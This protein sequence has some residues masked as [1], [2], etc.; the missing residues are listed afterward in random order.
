MSSHAARAQSQPEPTAPQPGRFRWRVVDIVVASVVA[1]ATG[2]LFWIW[3]SSWSAMS[4]PFAAFPPAAGLL[5][6]VWC[7]AGPLGALIIRKPGA[8]LYCEL[9]AATVS[10]L[11]GTQWGPQVLISGFIQGLGAELVFLLFFYRRFGIGVAILAGLGAGLFLG[12]SE[13]IMYNVEWA[14]TW[15]AVYTVT[16]SV[17]GALL[18]GLGAWLLVRAL[19]ASGALSAFAAGRSAREV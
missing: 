9:L 13:N 16:A 6:G 14:F 1:V 11:I 5:T 19:A 15:Q 17:S 4:V 18:A 7:L 3:S 12:V 8:A 10:A 2:V